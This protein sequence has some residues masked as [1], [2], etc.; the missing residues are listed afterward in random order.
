M[1]VIG[2]A[3]P[4]HRHYDHHVY[5]GHRWWDG[6]V[7]SLHGWDRTRAELARA[8][9]ARYSSRVEGCIQLRVRTH[10]G[11]TYRIDADPAFLDARDPGDLYA[12]LWGELER[13]GSLEIQDVYGQRH[14][15]PA[16]LIQEIQAAPCF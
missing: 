6:R 12:S 16:G 14:V 2:G 3:H 9:P 13:E 7:G 11:E 5:D 4:V 15:F 8:R 10:R 1:I